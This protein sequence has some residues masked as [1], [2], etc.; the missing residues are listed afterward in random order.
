MTEG[1]RLS[2]LEILKNVNTRRIVKNPLKTSLDIVYLLHFSLGLEGKNDQ[3]ILSNTSPSNPPTYGQE[4]YGASTK[5]TI[6]F[7]PVS[8]HASFFIFEVHCFSSGISGFGG[9][10]IGTSHSSPGSW[11][12]IKLRTIQH[13]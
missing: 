10:S 8:S 5:G 6:Q 4:Q 7:P 11:L 13:L 2:Q 12:S 1:G 9:F 3:K